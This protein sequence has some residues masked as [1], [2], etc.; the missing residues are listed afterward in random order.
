VVPAWLAATLTLFTHRLLGLRRPRLELALGAAVLAGTAFFAAGEGS[1]AYHAARPAWGAL[2]LLFALYPGFLTL[3]RAL[4]EPGLEPSLLL[5]A[6]LVLNAAGVHDVALANGAVPLSHDLAIAWAVVAGIALSAWVFVRRFIVALDTAES[7]TAQL[8]RRVAEKHA[9]LEANYA[10]LRLLE[11]ERAVAHERERL[12]AEIHDG[13]GGQLVS[14]LAMLRGGDAGAAAVE[15]AVQGA[16]D[17]MRLVIQ[18]LETGAEDLQGSL[19]TL[20]AR[21]GPRLRQAGLRV[22]WPVEDV[23]APPGFGPEKSLHVMRIVQEAVAN[24][25]KHARAE[26][27]RVRAGVEP[28]GGGRVFLSIEDDGA[29]M[30]DERAPR[31]AGRGLAN[32]RRRAARL[33]GA[34]EVRSGPAGTRVRLVLPL[35]GR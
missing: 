1:S 6:G 33:G 2:V 11:R 5:T 20:R 14:T 3:R 27:L 15:A 35:A 9:E 31:E 34:L 22:D 16:L 10:R 23:P 32:M 7:L 19:A 28:G 4:V 18:S 17:D 12:M 13:L 26:T 25:L 21:L 24:V 29:G 30:G 8:E